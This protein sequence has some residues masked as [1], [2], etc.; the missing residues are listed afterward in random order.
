MT[1]AVSGAAGGRA[2]GLPGGAAGGRAGGAVSGVLR[3]V[4]ILGVPVDALSLEEAAGLAA[5]WLDG[6]HDAAAAGVQGV[7]PDGARGGVPDGAR[8]GGPDGAREGPPSV[9][10][11]TRVVLTPNPEIIM[12]ARGDAELTAA[13]READLS[14]ADGIGVVWAARALG[15]PVPERVTGVDLLELLLG[16]LAR[17]GGG[18][19]FLGGR[20]GVAEEAA[21][22]ARARWPGL[23]VAGCH[24]GYFGPNEAPAVAAAVAGSGADLLVCGMGFP[25]DQKWLR[26]W[27]EGLGVRVAVGVGGAL[28]V[29]AGRVRRAPA[30]WRRL[31]LEWFH[32]LLTQPWRWR[33]MLALPRF[34]LA[35]LA[36]ARAG[37][38]GGRR[39]RSRS[40]AA[41]AARRR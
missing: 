28:D 31:H 37:H 30:A 40:A 34:C 12:A 41:A 27:R 24:H 17:R 8:D 35:V 39:R 25:R 7:A 11:A 14:L 22:R 15:N 32:R 6:A 1:G 38:G 4:F 9:R 18:V 23:R 3:R 10:P 2:G 16:H 13:L 26:R 5:R 20:P 29:L 21:G 33:R 19:Y 36:E